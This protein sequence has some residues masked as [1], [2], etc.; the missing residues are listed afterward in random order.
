MNTRQRNGNGH[1]NMN[2]NGSYHAASSTSGGG[3]IFSF[4]QLLKPIN[5][6]C[7]LMLLS[8]LYY[9]VQLK[10][11]NAII[12]ART[13]SKTVIPYTERKKS[14]KTTR[15][16]ILKPPTEFTPEIAWLMSFPN[17][18]T[19]FTMT[20]VS[21]ASNKSFATN[22]GDEVTAREVPMSTSIY[23]RRPEGPYWQGTETSSMFR[24]LKELPDKYVITKTHCGSRC[25]NCGPSQYVETPATFLRR[26]ASGH[27]R[28]PPKRRRID[29]E[30]PPS[31]VSKAI[32]LI[33]NPLHN[34]IARYH[35][36]RKHH[37]YKNR[38]EW[39]D[40]HPNDKRG[41]Q[42]WCKDLDRYF[43]KEDKKFFKNGIPE[44]PCHGEF[45]KYAQWHNFVHDGLKLIDTHDVPVLTVWY[46]NYT[47]AF[48][49]T[50]NQIMDFLELPIVG[51]L[52]EFSARSDYGDYF[53]KEQTA[54][55]KK[56]VKRV[57]RKET[58]EQVKH[59]FDKK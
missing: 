44:A 24:E 3:G 36:E 11:E 14:S 27:A 41:F 17:S 52:R 1:H 57:A 20:M 35:L 21:K 43:K 48:N 53:T 49:E 29:V 55:I 9:N 38:T 4:K 12:D 34:I 45:Y 32:H 19:S 13:T 26:C 47:L 42:R 46:E 39:L 6:V 58:W 8:G 22:Y 7:F 5:L 54:D 25:V 28:V 2:G 40:R 33:R 10:D 50:A 16:F 51:E 15:A 18:G 31:R 30:Y 23:P 59:Y 37:V 56:L